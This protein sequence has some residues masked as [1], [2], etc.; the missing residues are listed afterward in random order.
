MAVRQKRDAGRGMNCPTSDAETWRDAPARDDWA[1]A[2]ES[3][4]AVGPATSAHDATRQAETHGFVEDL[5]KVAR[6]M[7]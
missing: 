5:K 4:R 6:V 1:A 3:T 2:A 7:G